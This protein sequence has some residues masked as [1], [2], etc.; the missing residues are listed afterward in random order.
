MIANHIRQAIVRWATAAMVGDG[1]SAV[2]AISSQK[3]IH[4]PRRYRHQLSSS[5]SR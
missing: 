2:I 3:P 5:A 4:L 1:G